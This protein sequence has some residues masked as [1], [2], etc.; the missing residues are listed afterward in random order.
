MDRG[1]ALVGDAGA[2]MDPYY[3]PGLDFVAMS[4]CATVDIVGDD[5]RSRYGGAELPE[6][7]LMRRVVLHNEAFA[8]S[9]RRWID[10]L[11]V[12]KY[13]LLR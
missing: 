8:R 13:E 5:L 12:G 6:T 1:W 2:F 7:E 9:Y 3:S 10:A 11:Y 4:A